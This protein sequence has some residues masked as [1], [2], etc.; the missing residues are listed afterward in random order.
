MAEN[1]A[2]DFERRGLAALGDRAEV[3]GD[4]HRDVSAL[5]GAA[6]GILTQFDGQVIESLPGIEVPTL[7]VVGEDDTPFLDGSRYMAAKIPGA[8]LAVIPDAGHAPN[9]SNPEEFERV[10]TDFLATVP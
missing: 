9:I 10:M 6:R 3:S 4:V 5:I 1:Y 7:V 8:H 2:A